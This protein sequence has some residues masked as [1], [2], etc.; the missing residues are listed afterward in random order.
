ME[1]VRTFASDCFIQMKTSPS[2][3]A[4][5][6]RVIPWILTIMLAASVGVLYIIKLKEFARQ[7]YSF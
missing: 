2:I 6:E 3:N 7:Y 4:I 1:A 5:V